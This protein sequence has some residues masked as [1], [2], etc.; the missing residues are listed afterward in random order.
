MKKDSKIIKKII[1]ENP[2]NKTQPS[3][4]I[5]QIPN[6]KFKEISLKIDDLRLV[7]TKPEQ[8]IQGPKSKISDIV[9]V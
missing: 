4:K 6:P 5:T 9:L 3:H 8:V 7:E 2:D 1:V